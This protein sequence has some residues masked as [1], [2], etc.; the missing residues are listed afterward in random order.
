MNKEY[1]QPEFYHF[2]D[3]SIKLANYCVENIIEDGMSVLD[4][5]SGCGVVGLEIYR[6]TH[7][8]IK[9]TFNEIQP[10]MI[11]SLKYNLLNYYPEGDL[12]IGNYM[13]LRERTFDLIV[14]NPPFYD[15]SAGRK[16]KELNKLICKFINI[17]NWILLLENTKNL[18]SDKG[19]C[20]MILSPGQKNLYFQLKSFLKRNNSEVFELELNEQTN[21]LLFS[22]L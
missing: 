14:M 19:K 3:E 17:E 11:D 5:F 15:I 8:D 4:A 6:K 21:L 10:E 1:K 16:P 13:T 7:K 12:L 18:L 20:C 22:F 2:T 9:I